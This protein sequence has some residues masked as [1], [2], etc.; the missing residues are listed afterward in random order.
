MQHVVDRSVDIDGLGDVVI[1][2]SKRRIVDQVRDVAVT[3]GQKVIHADHLI[4]VAQ[5]SFAQVRSDEP[6]SSGDDC[7]QGDFS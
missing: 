6:R 1:E 3:A 2:K 4:A 7:S 5:E